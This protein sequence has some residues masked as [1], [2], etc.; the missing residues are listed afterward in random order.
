MASSED[1]PPKPSTPQSIPLQDLSR[2]P[3]G[4]GGSGNPRSGRRRA[5][6]N[7]RF[8]GDGRT[9]LGRTGLGSR[10]ERIAEGSP[11]RSE[12]AI[13]RRPAP[14]SQLDVPYYGADDEALSPLDDIH[15]FAA[16][17]ATLGL[18]FDGPPAHRPPAT[19]PNPTRTQ[20]TIITTP[21]NGGHNGIQSNEIETLFSPNDNDTTPLTNKQYLHPSASGSR[22]SPRG[23]R[24]DRQDQGSSVH[25]MDGDSPGRAYAQPGSR[26]GDDLPNVESGYGFARKQSLS[27]SI[28]RSS[29]ISGDRRS[30]SRSISPSAS[31]LFRANSMLRMMSQR[32][33]NLSNDT[34]MVEQSIRRKSSVRHARLEGPPSFPAMPDILHE[35][36]P[37]HTA[38]PQTPMEE[39]EPSIPPLQRPPV[40]QLTHPNPLRGKSWGIF[41]PENRLRRALCEMLVHPMTEPVIFALIVV[42]TVL[43][44][45]DSAPSV[46]NDPRSRGWGRSKIDYALFVLFVLYT[47]ELCARTIVSGFIWNSS[48]YSTFDTSIGLRR[49]IIDRLR[50]FFALG[51]QSTDRKASIAPPTQLSLIRSF[52]GMQDSELPGHGRQQQRVRLARRAFLRHSFNRIELIA[53]VSFWISFGLSLSHYE[54]RKHVYVF[55][56][57]SCLR[58]LRLLG[59]TSGTSIILRSLKRAAPLLVN[60]AFLISFFWLLFAIV[61]VQT[62]KSSL[63]RTCVWFYPD[64]SGNYTQNTFNSVVD[65]SM[66]RPGF[67]CHSYPLI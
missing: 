43:L 66:Q 63:R 2:P 54:S 16:A 35:P 61:G 21:S 41:G 31:P 23:Q 11:S 18:S 44:A 57:M 33:V 34:E 65:I 13:R 24:H 5:G 56:M 36:P 42:Q 58:I 26:L 10:Y 38:Q 62:F 50:S 14:S 22:P 64:G 28:G 20:P 53:V 6:R 40:R 67:Q 59:L 27:S 12:G 9:L 1:K 52:T 47:L 45:V 17:T 7:S 15:G 32:V 37:Q 4:E 48:E 55:R 25:F 60:V 51:R 8:S 29:P 39:K 19:P 30:R 46:T 49:A 3:D